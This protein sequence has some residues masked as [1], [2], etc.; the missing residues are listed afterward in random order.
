[1]RKEVQITCMMD[2]L[3]SYIYTFKKRKQAFSNVIEQQLIIFKVMFLI[4][5][6]TPHTQSG[7]K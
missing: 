5:I 6:P 4:E 2:W 7:K 3:S 1:M